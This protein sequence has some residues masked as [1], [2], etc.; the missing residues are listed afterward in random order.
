MS[1]PILDLLDKAPFDPETADSIDAV[2]YERAFAQAGFELEG[3]C[4]GEGP[5]LLTAF[6]EVVDR[7]QI[8]PLALFGFRLAD[9]YDELPTALGVQHCNFDASLQV[10]LPTVYASGNFDV[11]A[12]VLAAGVDARWSDTLSVERT[13][14]AVTLLW[15]VDPVDFD[16][17]VSSLFLI[18]YPVHL[19]VDPTSMVRR[20]EP[21]AADLIRLGDIQRI[22]R[23]AE[24]LV[25]SEAHSVS[26]SAR[27]FTTAGPFPVDSVRPGVSMG[28]VWAEL[29]EQ[30][31]TSQRGLPLWAAIGYGVGAQ[32]GD[33]I[34]T[35]VAS[36]F[37]E[38]GAAS[39]AE[40]LRALIDTGTSAQGVAWTDIFEL[41]S[42]RAEGELMI[43]MVRSADPALPVQQSLSSAFTSRS[44]LF[45]VAVGPE[46]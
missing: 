23:V 39:S 45:A 16:R 15:D 42:V 11:E 38:E 36:H 32:D 28:D 33:V 35:I 7:V 6:D 29:E 1:S 43:A 18:G 31:Q 3:L 27:P 5:E 44:E 24:E 17:P 19:E 40:Q 9:A 34:G 12:M 4:D 21:E 10:R 37:S 14:A 25:T 46:G 41:L 30:A 26:I 20:P 22:R 2:N 8:N 13:D